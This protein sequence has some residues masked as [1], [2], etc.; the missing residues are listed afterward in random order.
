MGQLDG[1]VALVTG[2]AIGIGRACAERLAREGAAV[3]VTDVQDQAGAEVVRSILQAGGRAEFL[4]LDVVSEESWIA[5]LG[6]TR[7][8]LGR[9]DVLVNNA[10][11]AARRGPM[12]D[13]ALADF[14]RQMAVNVEG[15]F[16]GCKHAIPLMAASGGGSIINLSSTAGLRGSPGM[17]GYSASK[18]A[19]RLFTK[20]VAMECAAARNGVR[21]NSV[22]PGLIETAIWTSIYPSHDGA[23]AAPDLDALSDRLVPV[24]FKGLP[25]DVANGVLWLASEESRY[26]TGTELVIDGGL[27]GR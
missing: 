19:V 5:A 25:E 24:G 14:R 3:V 10:G 8:R 15:V 23:A 4:H 17:A 12:V 22:H 27:S 7:A 1:K 21:V 16:L 13:M 20:A 6:E 26:V 18:G 9:L 11:I 2:A